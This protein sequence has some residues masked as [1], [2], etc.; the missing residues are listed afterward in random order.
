MRFL[1]LLVGLAGFSLHGNAQ[2]S[3]SGSLKIPPSGSGLET[4]PSAL[5]SKPSSIFDKPSSSS[6]SILE[7]EKN[8]N[9]SNPKTFTNPG[10]RYE[11]KLNKTPLTGE[12]LFADSNRNQYLGDIKAHSGSVRLYYRDDGNVDG[13]MVK[14][15]VNDKVVKE[16]LTLSGDFQG[17]TIELQDGFNKIEF[18]ALNEGFEAPNTAQFEIIDENG[19]VIHSSSWQISAGYKASVIVVK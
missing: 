14:I 8:W 1:L 18:E 4:P 19:N 2:D 7:K 6:G 3:G 9:F 17:F 10:T 13:D 16:S 12:I 5:P 15:Y 11:D